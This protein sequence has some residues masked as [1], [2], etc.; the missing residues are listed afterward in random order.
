MNQSAI[1]GVVDPTNLVNMLPECPDSSL[2][3]DDQ[4]SA[5]GGS[6]A[7]L[8]FWKELK[9]SD[10]YSTSFSEAFSNAGVV[11]SL[12]AARV[13][14]F[15]FG[16]RTG[17]LLQ[18]IAAF[19][20]SFDSELASAWQSFAERVQQSKYAAVKAIDLF[21]AG[22]NGQVYRQWETEML[23]D[24]PHAIY[25]TSPYRVGDGHVVNHDD[26][27]EVEAVMSFQTHTSIRVVEGVLGH[28]QPLLK[29]LYRP[30]GRCVCVIDENVEKFFGWQVESYFAAHEIELEK[31][32]YRAMEVD[33]GISTVERL[34]GDF[35]H[36]GV[37]RN[38][39][40]LIIGGGVLSD[41]A[42]LACS[43]Y[44]R[45]TP[46]VML[47]TSV[48]AGIDAGPSPR[49]CCDGFGYKNLFGAYHPPILSI[50]D[51]TFFKT[52]R[53]G[54]LRHGIAEIIKMAVVKDAELFSDLEAAGP[55][56]IETRFGS[57]G[58]AGDAPLQTL[59]NRILGRAIRSYVA[60]EYGN[61]YETHQCR[62]HA[63]GHTWSP[64]FEIAAG[65]LHGHAVSVGMGW[66]AFLG[67]QSRLDQ[68]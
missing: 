20:E 16:L 3:L 44:H 15:A 25:P 49:T 57:L 39:P 36:L 56:L 6:L 59:S 28:D 4:I 40:V 12:P 18:Q 61:L 1:Y 29:D 11:C 10:V 34:L 53:S 27:C 63:Y 52:L 60:A 54:W 22:S 31:V 35:K 48:V 55:R 8:D 65:L 5:W 2:D 51:R 68:Y 38:E 23:V 42:G 37:L 33:K 41:T 14:R 46:Y 45:G 21:K 62:P 17:Q 7:M 66:G 58:A 50:T 13:L 67:S 64:G 9:L 47:S 19:T 32:V 26:F 24:D 43:L 30:L